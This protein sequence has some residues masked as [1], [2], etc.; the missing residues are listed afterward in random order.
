MKY[1]YPIIISQGESMLIANIP[2]FD[3]STQG[4]DLAEAIYMARDAIGMMGL[5]YLEDKKEF[6][7]PSKL[8]DLTAK[9]D[10]I[11]TLV[12]VDFEDYRKKYENRTVR[13]NVSLPCWL[14][15]AAEKEN[16]NF[17]QLLQKALKEQLNITT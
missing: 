13:K 1:V 14:N 6:P 7:T 12:D 10:E 8:T 2:D 15:E 17:S 9:A 5:D 16:I 4:A 11:V 3:I